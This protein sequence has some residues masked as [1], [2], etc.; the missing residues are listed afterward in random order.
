MAKV[1]SLERQL[2]EEQMVAQRLKN[3]LEQRNAEF[4]A[5][6]ETIPQQVWTAE[7]DGT[8]NFVNERVLKFFNRT[9]EEMIGW[10]WKE[11]IHPDDLPHC[12]EKWSEALKTGRPYEIEFRLK[13]GGDGE[14]VWH[15]GRAL[16]LRNKG[17][18]IVKWMGTNTDI[19]SRK[20]SE[21]E[22]VK[23][24]EF[25]E[26]ANQAKSKFLAAMSHEIRTPLNAIIGMADVLWDDSSL[27][28]NQK[29]TIR[30][31]RGAGINLLT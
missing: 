21:E 4:Q 31:I 19:S 28:G 6:I 3:Q 1:S 30:V 2:R 8:L 14:F 7:P 16:P 20:R 27:V 9:F 29:E 17:G 25:A 13:R 18:T 26:A 10:N 12:L 23:A 11:V 24:K 5:F 22:L 15:L